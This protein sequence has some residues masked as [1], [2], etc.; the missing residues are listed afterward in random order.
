MKHR[1]KSRQP[2]A[3]LLSNI[4]PDLD[5]RWINIFY[6]LLWDLMKRRIDR[7]ESGPSFLP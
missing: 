2:P 1:L 5:T 3:V 6:W 4:D 7:L